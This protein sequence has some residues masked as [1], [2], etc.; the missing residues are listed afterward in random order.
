MRNISSTG[1]AKITSQ[2][3][4]EPINVIEIDWADLQA[5]GTNATYLVGDISATATTITVASSAGF[6]G[7]GNFYIALDV[8]IMLCLYINGTQL[9]VVRGV[10]GTIPVEHYD[11]TQVIEYGGLLTAQYAD[12]DIPGPPFI[13]GRIIDIGQIDDAINIDDRN[14]QTKEVSITLDDTDGTIKTI[15]DNYDVHN[16]PVRVYQWFNGLQPGDM[17][18]VFSGRINTPITWTEHDRTVKLTGLSHIEDQ[19][20]GFSVEEG[21]FSYIPASMVG[22][23]WPQIFG[24]IYDYPALELDLMVQGETMTGIGILTG[25]AAF[26]SAPLYGNGTNADYKKLAQIALQEAHIDFLSQAA[27]KWDFS[28]LPDGHTKADAYNKQATDIINQILQERFQMARSEQCLRARR[29]YQAMVAEELMQYQNPVQIL[30][31]EDF[32]QKVNVTL[33]IKG[34][35]VSG[36]FNG[37]SFYVSGV[38]DPQAQAEIEA[39]IYNGIVSQEIQN[40]LCP[41]LAQPHTQYF[42]Y[43]TQVPC[44][45][46]ADSALCPF[47]MQGFVSWPAT[48]AVVPPNA[49][50]KQTWIDPGTQV[51]LYDTPTVTY[52]ASTT[53]GNVLSVKAFRSEN[54]ERSLLTLDP[55]TYTV[56]TV[57]F[58]PVTA[59]QIVLNQRLSNIWFVDRLGNYVKG[60]S[61][62]IYVSFQS[63]VGPNIVDILKYIIT[64]YTDLAYDPVSFAAV[65]AYLAPFPANFPLLERKNVLAILQEITFQARCAFWIEDEIIYLKYLPVQPAPVDSIVV[66][67]LDSEHS[68]VVELTETENLVTKMNVKWHYGYILPTDLPN[69]PSQ[70]VQYM[71]LRHNVGRYGLHERDYDWYIFNQPD[72]VLK[73]ATFWLIR[74]STAWK[75]VK[76]RTY[77]NKLNLEAFD[78]VTF[79]APGYVANAAVPVIVEK[80]AYNSAENG[81]DFD[82]I[83]PVRPGTM[84]QDQYFWPSALPPSIKWPPQD[85]INSGD[86]GGSNFLGSLWSGLPVD[87]NTN[88]WQYSQLISAIRQIP[89]STLYVL[90]SVVLV[91]GINTAFVGHADWGDATPG[92]VGFSAQPIPVPGAVSNNAPSTPGFFK[93]EFLP[94]SAPMTVAPDPAQPVTIDMGKTVFY[95]STSSTPQAGGVLKTLL[96]VGNTG[97][98]EID[99]SRARL[100]DSSTATAITTENGGPAQGYPLNT[101]LQIATNTGASGSPAQLA[102]KGTVPFVTT[103][104]P[105]G[106]PFDF[107]YD[108]TGKKL[109]AGTAFL[110]AT[111]S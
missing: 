17:F 21:L 54:G 84:V 36:S 109:G 26:L 39:Q 42:D 62:E 49:E 89:T 23:P 48:P 45:F 83:A 47:E 87:L 72:I 11:Q 6:N 8:E 90:G 4:A 37:Q 75:R 95:D 31:G 53:P 29:S 33:L 10:K 100:Q 32:P 77:L 12:R 94:D 68:V 85:D 22:K 44:N 111:S 55:S 16:R 18:L 64:T 70:E 107:K 106:A 34:C 69:L 59:T 27:F 71:I 99:I 9:S 76:F 3:G 43:K 91:G 60:W 102:I 52:I 25:E 73:M 2:Y 57:Q 41:P 80:A 98:I 103:D 58:G 61:D 38:S 74:L 19:E 30:A 50:M 1:L 79:N 28:S 88:G 5:T 14:N 24:T 97:D 35:L 20:A 93:M 15:L 78:C 66:S 7:S 101:V 51:Y 13:P 86:A 81:I 82:C 104:A 96:A 56:S 46:S 105:Q 67:D 40:R 108:T 65:S 63:T 92:D 110:Q